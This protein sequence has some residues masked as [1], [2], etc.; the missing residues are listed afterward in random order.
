MPEFAIRIEQ[1]LIAVHFFP[2]RRVLKTMRRIATCY[3]HRADVLMAAITIAAI[4]IW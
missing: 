2:P 3:D 4:I 1:I